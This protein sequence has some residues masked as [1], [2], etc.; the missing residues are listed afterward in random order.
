MEPPTCLT[1]YCF[2]KACPVLTSSLVD[3]LRSLGNVQH[4]SAVP[5]SLPF[6][7][8]SQTP[9][10][11]AFA[12]LDEVLAWLSQTMHMFK[13]STS[14]GRQML[15]FWKNLWEQNGS[16]NIETAASF[17]GT[18]KAGVTKAGCFMVTPSGE[19]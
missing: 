10:P 3:P 19:F 9:R 18:R 5:P 7:F 6:Q 16:H 14:L 15:I 12:P 11:E 17:L 2:C 1:A 13:E 8:L 4:F